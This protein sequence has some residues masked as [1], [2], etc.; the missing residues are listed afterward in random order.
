MQCPVTTQSHSIVSPQTSPNCRPKPPQLN[1]SLSA[2][3]ICWDV[4]YSSSKR[5]QLL[6]QTAPLWNAPNT[7]HPWAVQSIVPCRAHAVRFATHCVLRPKRARPD[8]PTSDSRRDTIIS[9]LPRQPPPL[10][11]KAFPPRATLEEFM[12]CLAAHPCS[13]PLDVAAAHQKV[14][15]AR[16]SQRR[17]FKL[18]VC[19]GFEADSGMRPTPAKHWL[20]SRLTGRRRGSP[21]WLRIDGKK[22][23]AEWWAAARPVSALDFCW[24]REIV[25]C[26][27]L[28]PP[29]VFLRWMVFVV[30]AKDAECCIKPRRLQ[31]F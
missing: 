10:V 24:S 4:T 28:P 25:A 27:G 22:G 15:A 2:L 14:L 18:T 1:S 11:P 16:R 9:S 20:R 23:G 5:H 26:W 13:W 17:V 7:R 8:S 31:T 12:S 3:P 21:E 29:K 6:R 30:I 19:T